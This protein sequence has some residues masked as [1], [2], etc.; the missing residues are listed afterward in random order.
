MRRYKM[1]V[2]KELHVTGKE[3]FDEIAIAVM[4]DYKRNTNKT[5]HVSQIKPGLKYKKKMKGR[6]L[7]QNDVAIKVIDF[8]PNQLYSVCFTSDVDTTL[9]SYELLQE[10]GDSIVI[11]YSE[12]YEMNQNSLLNPEE[13]QKK[14]TIKKFERLLSTIEKEILRKRKNA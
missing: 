2:E 3:F 11:E 5:I 1:K 13:F 7:R 9:V 6:G 14:R 4:A 8:I 10:K 12:R